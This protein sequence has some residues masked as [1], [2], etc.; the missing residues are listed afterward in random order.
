M[1]CGKGWNGRGWRK[2]NPF[3]SHSKAEVDQLGNFGTW[4]TT[5]KAFFYFCISHLLSFFHVLG[6]IH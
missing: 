5:M 1:K 6:P 2:T 4:G 3:L